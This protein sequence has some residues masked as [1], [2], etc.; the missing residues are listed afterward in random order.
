MNKL[1]LAGQQ[2][3]EAAQRHSQSGINSA[4]SPEN[5]T[6]GYSAS[7]QYSL[8]EIYGADAE[9]FINSQTTSDVKALRPYQWQPSALLDRKAHVVAY[10][11]L[12]RKNHSYR[13]IAEECQVATILE[14]LDKYIFSDKVELLNLSAGRMLALIGS[15]ARIIINDN[16]GQKNSALFE[17]DLIDGDLCG[18]NVH[19]FRAPLSSREAFL[20]YCAGEQFESL[21]EKLLPILNKNGARKLTEDDLLVE[22][23]EAGLPQFAKDFTSENLIIELGLEDKAISYTKGCFQGQEVLARVKG[24]GSPNKQL[25]GLILELKSNSDQDSNAKIEIGTPLMVA[26]QEVAKILSNG[27]S[28]RMQKHIALA[29]VKRDYRTPGRVLDVSILADSSLDQ[30]IL[31][32]SG[33]ATI[34]MLPF[35]E[36]ED[37][38]QKAR[39][40][41]EEAL[42]LYAAADTNQRGESENKNR[43][44]SSNTEEAII[45]LRG[46]LLFDSTLEDAYEALGVILSKENQLDEAVELM[47]SLARINPDSIMAYA[48]LSVFY[49]EQGGG[50]EKAEEAKAQSMSIRMRLAAKEA[51]QEH[52]Q[53]EDTAKI[54]AEALE[55]KAMFEQVIE[56]DSDDLFANNGLGN[57]YNILQQYQ[58]AEPYLLKAIEIKPN[59]TVAYQELGR[60]YEG[61][62]QIEKAIETFKRGI[63]VAAQKGDMTPLKAMQARLD[64]LL[65]KPESKQ[66]SKQESSNAPI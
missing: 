47:E 5:D 15:D 60:T 33:Q 11:N 23:V 65:A 56:I 63:D 31:E 43:S 20:I 1:K 36:P 3:S 28:K 59:H 35:I 64:C 18:I 6:C 2:K 48:N 17:R 30:A 57:C 58:L 42:R 52:L 45:K 9:R 37:L 8:I 14:H 38:K 24:H 27:Y 62:G 66:D 61:L 49:L 32:T 7:A 21:I 29:M 25:A 41:Y 39:D 53:K 19:I 40:L 10:F 16:L 34:K 12:Y 55:R 51:M 26:G 13:I 46:A 4:L 22:R 54:E 50:K 44:E